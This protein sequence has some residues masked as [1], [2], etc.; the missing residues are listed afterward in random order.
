MPARSNSP[1]RV[2]RPPSARALPGRALGAIATC[3]LVLGI[4]GCSSDDDGG[5]A[6]TEDSERPKVVA[7]TGVAADI[8]SQV[9]GEGVEVVQLV[10]DGASPHSYSPSAKDRAEIAEADLAVYFSPRLEESLPIDEAER[11]FAFDGAVLVRTDNQDPHSWLAPTLIRTAVPQLADELAAIDP[12]GEGYGLRASAYARRLTALDREIKR[13]VA[14]IPEADRKLVT[15][16]DLMRFYAFRYGFTVVGAPFGITPEAEADAGT[17]AELIERVEAQD[18][19]AVFAQAGDDPEVLRRIAEEAG[20][21]V[22]DDLPVESPTEDAPTYEEM[23]RVTTQKIVEAL[24][25]ESPSK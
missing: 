6:G 19:P 9:A 14:T 24:G 13:E 4:A 23:L 2:L 20:V 15:S 21:E 17:V 10:P 12:D 25:G 22:V 1:S 7:S 16:H 8:V 5:A 18:V 11:R 3:A